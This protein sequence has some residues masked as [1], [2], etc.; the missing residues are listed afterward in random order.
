MPSLIGDSFARVVR[1]HRDRVAVHGLS[2]GVTRTFAQVSADRAA[3]ETTLAA[4]LP[5]GP[6]CVLSSVGNRAGFFP[7]FL[8]CLARGIS[9]VLLDVD[10]NETEVSAV[11]DRF[12]A[13]A[14][15]ARAGPSTRRRNDVVALPAGLSL[16]RCT[17]PSSRPWQPRA[18]SS[19]LVLRVTSGSTGR[20]KAVVTTE[21]QLASD[22]AH[23]IEAMGLTSEDVSLGMIP[24]SHAYGMATLLLPLLL[25][26]TP[27]ALRDT[28]VPQMLSNDVTSYRVTALP[29]VPF[30]YDYLRRHG[31]VDALSSLRLLVTAGAPL[32]LEI[33]RHFKQTIR[34]KIH[35][36]YGTSETG[37]IAFDD[38]DALIAP[39]TVGR[40]VRDV[41][42]TL[43][44]DAAATAGEGR[45]HVKGTAVAHGYAFA[46]EPE[47][48]TRFVHGGVLTG[49]LARR[50]DRGRLYLTGRLSR[51][52]NVAGRKVQPEEVERVIGGVSG[53]LQAFVVG[54]PHPTRG[55]LLAAC[56]QRR[57]PWVTPEGIRAACAAR[58]SSHKIPRRIVFADELPVDVR[59]KTSRQAV[60]KLVTHMLEDDVT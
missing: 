57:G 19:S 12:G 36:L 25:Q 17:P 8:S 53:V 1:D 30:V 2:E 46:D 49:D 11:A 6:A 50:D 14:I 26:G 58:L 13:D 55:Q 23:A 37:A 3:M 4:A 20:P 18:I 31:T 43:R 45:V 16:I 24:M 15:V 42:V 38:S 47:D 51:F 60:A 59:G 7:L 27:I 34:R 32:D 21:A 54:L 41:I 56:V 40:P 22:G 39:L 9:L 33:V 10:A 48:G 28:F 44:N 35:S 52:V 5:S 29:T